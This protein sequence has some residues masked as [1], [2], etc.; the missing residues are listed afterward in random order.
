MTAG[1]AQVAQASNNAA[2]H[3][4][5]THTQA[6]H[7]RGTLVGRAPAN[8]RLEVSVALALRNRSQVDRLIE[9]RVVLSRAQARARFAPTAATARAVRAYL[10]SQG[11][12]HITVAGDRM[13]V[14]GYATVAQVD[15]AF[16]TTISSYRM[17]RQTVY[18]NTTAAKVPAA[19]GGKV[20][21]VLGLS[22]VQMQLPSLTRSSRKAG[23]VPCPD[24][25]CIP[26]TLEMPQIEQ[27]YQANTLPPASNTAIALITEGPMGDVIKALRGEEKQN[28]YPVVPV[29]VIPDSPEALDPNNPG[30]D[31][32]EWYLDTQISTAM[33]HEVSALDLYTIG[34]FTDSEVARGINEF[35]TQDSANDLS[36]SLGECD[37]LAFLDGAM[38]A[39]DG[40]LALG[41]TQ[42]QSSFSSTGDNGYACP[43]VASTG[44]PEGPP[45]VSWPA[46]GYYTA[47]AGGTSIY[48][49]GT[50]VVDEMAWSGGGGGVSPW[51]AAPSWTMQANPF[52]QSWQYTNQ[53]GRAVP[54]ISAVADG[55]VSPVDVY[56]VGGVGGTSISSPLSMGLWARINNIGGDTY[57][58]ASWNFYS[59]YN[60][61]NPGTVSPSGIDTTY[62]VP[63]PT[64]GP[65]SGFADITQG[66][67]GG[68]VATPGWDDC[69]GIGEIR[70]ADL[71]AAIAKQIG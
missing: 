58:L 62:Y 67:N 56:S 12:T 7:L 70:A 53:G 36:V 47:A 8:Q 39:S 68:C 18:A 21:A 57:G 33:A 16:D 23:A 59:V 71:A 51:E 35:V 34:T 55:T 46:D 61:T 31:S 38:I 44:V 48:G 49:N 32:L 11:F 54:D 42:G 27:I 6:L 5:A 66:T 4:A 65:V 45:G 50:T 37:I 13:L 19:L 10:A 69:T 1:L 64:P 2:A 52:G 20:V 41:A 14:T 43:E 9:S 40:E 30:F 63:D 25:I 15:R 22:D 17:G 60:A 3:W 28:G 29:N 24:G 26:N